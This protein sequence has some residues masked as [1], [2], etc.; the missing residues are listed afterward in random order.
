MPTNDPESQTSRSEKEPAAPKDNYDTL[1]HIA[2]YRHFGRG[3][4]L[5]QQGQRGGESYIIMSGLV[6][7]SRE[8]GGVTQEIDQ[9][10]PNNVIG[11]MA[12]ISDMSRMASATALEDT[13][14]IA[15]SRSSM[16]R[17]LATIDIEIRTTIEF[18]IDYIRGTVSGEVVDDDAMRRQHQILK[19]IVGDAGTK[20]RLKTM[21]PMLVLLCSCL[22][23]RA[24]ERLRQSEIAE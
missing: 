14:C 3:E 24:E 18:L 17:I 20:E 9:C 5:F 10:G 19:Y 15:L 16:R 6:R 12:I 22:I 1:D 13:V 8:E 11:E 2:S 4:V 7:I 23:K 21:E